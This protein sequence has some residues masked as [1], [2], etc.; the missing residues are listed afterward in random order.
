M[1]GEISLHRLIGL[2]HVDRKH[3]ESSVGEL[4]RDIVPIDAS[5]SQYLHQRVQNSNRTTFP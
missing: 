5:S 4:F 1:L 2:E 3:D